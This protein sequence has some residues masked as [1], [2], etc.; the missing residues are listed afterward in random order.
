MKTRGFQTNTKIAFIAFSAAVLAMLGS[1]GVL[2]ARTVSKRADDVTLQSGSV[3]FDSQYMPVMLLGESTVKSGSDG[4]YYLNTDN[5]K[6]ISLGNHSMAYTDEGVV[7]FGGGYR[8]D[9]SGSITK[10]ND[11]EAYPMSEDALYKLADRRYVVTSNTITDSNAKLVT[12]DYLYIVMDVVGNA[13]MYSNDL[14]MKTTQPTTIKFGQMTFDVANEVLNSEGSVMDLGKLIGT[15]NTYDSGLMKAIEETQTPDDITISVKG[16]DGGAGGTGGAGGVGGTGGTGGDGGMGGSGGTGGDGGMGGTGGMGG[17]GGVGGA[18]GDGA[19]AEDKASVQQITLTKVVSET[20]DSVTANYY[21]L[22]P[23]GALGVVYMELHPKSEMDR[24]GLTPAILYSDEIEDDTVLA[25]IESYWGEY[26]PYYRSSISA[27]N[28]TYTFNGLTPNTTYYV[29]MGH[30]FFGEDQDGDYVQ[31]RVLDDYYRITT[32][33][34]YSSLEMTYM[35]EDRIGI[36]LHLDGEVFTNNMRIRVMAYGD[37]GEEE[38]H[39]SIGN[40]GVTDP[41]LSEQNLE[42]ALRSG[43]NLDL[44]IDTNSLSELKK[45]PSIR[46]EL[47]DSDDMTAVLSNDFSNSFH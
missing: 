33:K 9:G 10:L 22:D 14:S 1:V 30:E 31:K 16:G 25:N 17:A 2:A 38:I 41:S 35:Q 7:I 47:Y 23:F 40:D 44:N 11:G 36:S 12:K 15:S 5:G 37:D 6:K 8:V 24:F 20:N 21:F 32:L 3:V 13:R 27:Y 43:L 45:K 46:I 18:G 29:V 19:I 26:N 28:N 42:D 39:Y 4:R 34:R